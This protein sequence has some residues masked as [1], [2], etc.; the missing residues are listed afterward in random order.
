MLTQDAGRC[1]DEIQEYREHQQ[2]LAGQLEDR[3]LNVQQLQSNADNL[4]ADIERLH[5]AKQ[6]VGRLKLN[7]RSV[8]LLVLMLCFRTCRTFWQDNNAPSITSS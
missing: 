8:V 2:E 6:K 4:D 7:S 3:Q 5:D 1:D